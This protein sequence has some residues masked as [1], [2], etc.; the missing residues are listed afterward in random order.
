MPTLRKQPRENV[1]PTLGLDDTFGHAVLKNATRY[2]LGTPEPLGPDSTELRRVLAN[3][4]VSPTQL[5]TMRPYL[6]HYYNPHLALLALPRNN[7]ENTFDY[8]RL[9]PARTVPMRTRFVVRGRGKP[10]PYPLEDE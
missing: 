9:P 5:E 3:V 1:A 10:K 7:D 6:H 4:L 8:E 2:Q